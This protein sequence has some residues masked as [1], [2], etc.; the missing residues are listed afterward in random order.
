ML[1]VARF[2]A[3]DLGNLRRGAGYKVEQ[4]F[5]DGILVNPMICPIIPH[6][7]SIVAIIFSLPRFYFNN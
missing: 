5:R 4:T 7:T 6:K 2:V 1:A 3:D